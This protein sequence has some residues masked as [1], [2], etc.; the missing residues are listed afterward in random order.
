[1]SLLSLPLLVVFAAGVR[2]RLAAPAGDT[3]LAGAV[4]MAVAV[5]VTAGVAQMATSIDGLA[6]EVVLARL[7]VVFDWNSAVLFTPGILAMG[8]SAA[9]GG[10]GPRGLP[11]WLAASAAVVALGAIAP[12]IGAPLLLLWVLVTSV[13]LVTERV[14]VTA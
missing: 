2:P 9:I 13:V 5:V 12:W 7:I 10:R 8:A 1:M 3:F 6:E 11:G 4:L 14:P